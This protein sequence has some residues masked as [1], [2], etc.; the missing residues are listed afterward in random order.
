MTRNLRGHRKRVTRR[1]VPGGRR[2]T[3]TTNI[4]APAFRTTHARTRRTSIQLLSPL[5]FRTKAPL[6]PPVSRAPPPSA[7]ASRTSRRGHGVHHSTGLLCR[8]L[9]SSPLSSQPPLPL[10]Y[11]KSRNARS[12]T[13]HRQL[14]RER[15]RSYLVSDQVTHNACIARFRPWRSPC[16]RMDPTDVQHVLGVARLGTHLTP[17]S[18]RPGLA[19]RPPRGPC[20]TQTMSEG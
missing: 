4:R 12:L 10:S 1:G 9:P 8:H 20:R 5:L 2:P 17:R 7:R 18:Q 13:H 6:A 3:G 19:P 15:H 14:G 16:H 11:C